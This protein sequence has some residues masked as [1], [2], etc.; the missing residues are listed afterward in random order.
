MRKNRRGKTLHLIGGGEEG[1][2][3]SL[4]LN[5]FEETKIFSG[6]FQVYGELQKQRGKTRRN[7]RLFFDARL[8]KKYM[9]DKVLHHSWIKNSSEY[10]KVVLL[11]K[12]EHNNGGMNVLRERDLWILKENWLKKEE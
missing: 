5:I 3:W 1:D 10:T 11:D 6:S 7:D 2:V 8:G 12:S 9:V 4:F